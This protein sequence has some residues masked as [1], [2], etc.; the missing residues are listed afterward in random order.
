MYDDRLVFYIF[1]LQLDRHSLERVPPPMPST[2]VY[3]ANHL[4]HA[5]HF[6]LTNKLTNTDDIGLY[7]VKEKKSFLN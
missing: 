7:V 5:Q 3:D 4:N 2:S 6:R 1:L